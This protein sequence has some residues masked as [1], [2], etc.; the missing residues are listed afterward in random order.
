MVKDV[1][2]GSD[3]MWAE[4]FYVKVGHTSRTCGALVFDGSDSLRCHVWGEEVEV[5]V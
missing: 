2:E 3:S 5:S 1:G 4:V